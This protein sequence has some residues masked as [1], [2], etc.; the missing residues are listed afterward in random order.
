LKKDPEL[1]KSPSQ[2]I[3]ESNAQEFNARA[4]KAQMMMMPSFGPAGFMNN[5]PSNTSR[6]MT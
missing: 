5:N 4:K 1:N 2:S 6:H 3:A